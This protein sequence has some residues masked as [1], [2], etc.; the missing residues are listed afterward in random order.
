MAHHDL[1]ALGMLE[2]SSVGKGIESADQMVKAADVA[3]LFFRTICP[4]KF[5]AAVYGNTAAVQ[6]SVSAGLA[7]GGTSVVDWLTLANIHPE[8]LAALSGTAN[9][10]DQNALGILE[11]FSAASIV[12]AADAAVKAAD[13]RLLDVRIAM[14]LG[15]KGYALMS[16]D[17]AAVQASV[18]AGSLVAGESGLLVSQVTIPRPAAGVWSQIL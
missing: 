7:V 13:V 17:V 8:V 1:H 15:G 6:A 4:G 18:K 5:L 2:F 9:G 14:G 11:T 16:G 10:C 3:P 12:L